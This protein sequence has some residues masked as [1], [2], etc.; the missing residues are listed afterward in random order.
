MLVRIFKEYINFYFL[1]LPMPCALWPAFHTSR[2]HTEYF[3]GIS[4]SH[5][6][7]IS[8]RK[9]YIF[10]QS[11]SQCA[12]F[13]RNAIILFFIVGGLKSKKKILQILNCWWTMQLNT[14]TTAN[15]GL[16]VIMEKDILTKLL[17]FGNQIKRGL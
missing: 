5:S 16:F 13:T 6:W 2:Y 3:W 7:N 9:Y 14:S 11:K 15:S 8:R 1:F 17:K 4:I 12:V 10:I